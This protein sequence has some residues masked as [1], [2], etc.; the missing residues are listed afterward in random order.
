M[1]DNDMK[2]LII[3]ADDFGASP[4]INRGILE[5]HCQGILTSTSLMVDMPAAAEA[6][7]LRREVPKVSI[8]LHVCLTKEDANLV[9]DPADA[10]RVRA[11]LQRQYAR[12]LDLL[13]Q[14]PT[15]IDAHHNIH[16]N[17]QLLPHFL[18]L[19]RMHP[20]PLRENSPVRYFSSFYGQWDGETHL[21]QVSVQSLLHMLR[22]EIRDGYTELSCHPG[23]IEPDLV[24]CYRQEREAELHTLCDP[25]VRTALAELQITP[26]SYHDFAVLQARPEGQE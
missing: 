8:G 7:Q 24:S 18:E 1:G 20:L 25:A 4:G 16:R 17:R 2:Y 3:N 15:H 10:E 21:E 23:Y 13:G 26:I 9:L 12:C 14:P 22:M 11:E 5:A 6:A 19:A